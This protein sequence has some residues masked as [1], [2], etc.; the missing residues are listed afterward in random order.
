MKFAANGARGPGDLVRCGHR[1]CIDIVNSNRTQQKYNER[2]S[3]SKRA[4]SSLIGGYVC[5]CGEGRVRMWCACVRACVRAYMRACVRV[6]ACVPMCQRSYYVIAFRV[7]VLV[8]QPRLLRRGVEVRMA[9]RAGHNTRGGS[10]TASAA[11]AA[12]VAKRRSLQSVDSANSFATV[13]S[14]GSPARTPMSVGGASIADSHDGDTV[15]STPPSPHGSEVGLDAKQAFDGRSNSSNSRSSSSRQLRGRGGADGGD[16][17]LVSRSRRDRSGGGSRQGGRR[18]TSSSSSSSSSMSSKPGSGSSTTAERPRA[19]ARHSTGSLDAAITHNNIDMKIIVAITCIAI[20]ASL[21]PML[22][23]RGMQGWGSASSGNVDGDHGS[24]GGAAVVDT[25]GAGGGGTIGMALPP[26]FYVLSVFTAV[27]L[28]YVCV[29]VC[30]CAPSSY[31]RRSNHKR[32]RDYC[33]CACARCEC[34]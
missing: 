19:I 34:Q 6:R 14:G 7:Q 31:A 10:I 32:V 20:A 15:D 18:I 27:S 9:R 12:I 5:S 29:C 23:A 24:S 22:A 30:V 4:A 33:V 1:L 26:L 13:T 3:N 11:A 8:F 28:V 17:G 25:T 16:G 21:A 2:L